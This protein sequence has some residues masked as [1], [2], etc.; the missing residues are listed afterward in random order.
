VYFVDWSDI[1]IDIFDL[2]TYENILLFTANVG[3]AEVKGLEGDITW[4]ATDALTLSAAFS[5]NDTELTSVPSTASNLVPVGSEL[6][7]TAN[8]QGNINVRYDFQ[9]AGKDAYAQLGVY[10]RGDSSTTIVAADNQE[11]SDYTLADVSFGVH[12]NEWNLKL[13]V[14]NLTDERTELFKSIQ[15]GPARTVTSRPRTVGLKLSRDF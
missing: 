4:L 6:P 3:E 8:F 14:T 7:L 5:V 11:L 15:D 10:H 9:M 12:V 1:Q 2:V 13:F